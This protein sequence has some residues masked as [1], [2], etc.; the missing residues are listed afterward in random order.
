VDDGTTGVNRGAAGGADT[1]AGTA[2]EPGADVCVA[3]GG[4]AK[5]IP[6]QDSQRSAQPGRRRMYP[7]LTDVDDCILYK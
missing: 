5:P 1:P 4:A 2:A 6:V 3:A 7:P